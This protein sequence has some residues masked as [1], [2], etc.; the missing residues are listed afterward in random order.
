VEAMTLLN[1]IEIY[2]QSGIRTFELLNDDLTKL[3]FPVDL[4]I[5][6]AVGSHFSPWNNTVIG[7]LFQELGVSV[8][9]HSVEPEMEFIRPAGRIW[10]SRPIDP[11]RIHRLMCVEIP[12]GGSNADE[13]VRQSFRILPA[14]ETAAL[15]LKTIC[16]PVLRAGLHGLH[17]SNVIPPII[18]GAQWALRV[19]KATDRICF[20]EISSKRAN[21]MSVAMDDVLGRV[22]VA[23]PT[24]GLVELILTEISKQIANLDIADDGAG[25]VAERISK[26]IS[27]SSRSADVG[28][29]GRLLREFVLA[30]VLSPADIKKLNPYETTLE[31]RKIMVAEWVIGYLNLLHAFGNEA[32]HHKTQNTTP[33]EIDGYDLGICLFAIQRVL[34]FWFDWRARRSR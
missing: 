21:A 10:V 22:S 32:A 24:G 13:I 25:K 30:H 26:A 3:D 29:A 7:T 1:S 4:L 28:M 33:I 6:S 18:E 31:L 9:D 15:P 17:V 11:R 12:H 19:L 16:L 23:V 2:T 27:Q 14:L 8:A 5:I 20:V 34:D